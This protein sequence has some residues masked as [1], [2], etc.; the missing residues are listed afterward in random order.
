MPLQHSAGNRMGCP[1]AFEAAEKDQA[2][3]D[4]HEKRRQ[5]LAISDGNSCNSGSDGR[6]LGA[7]SGTVARRPRLYSM[8]RS[9]G[10]ERRLLAF[11]LSFHRTPASRSNLVAPIR[12]APWPPTP[13]TVRV[14]RLRL[15]ELSEVAVGRGDRLFHPYLG[16]HGAMD[17]FLPR[18]KPLKRGEQDGAARRRRAGILSRADAGLDLDDSAAAAQQQPSACSTTTRRSMAGSR[19][20]TNAIRKLLW[21]DPAIG[22]L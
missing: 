12:P 7:R 21:P 13:W 15:G 20:S 19:P 8:G 4:E 16:P 18:H 2:K 9:G 22:E 3:R 11:Q 5:R 1:F 6:I 10:R 14:G 17:Q